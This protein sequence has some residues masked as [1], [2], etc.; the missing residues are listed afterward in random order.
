MS[1]YV[2]MPARSPSAIPSRAEAS[3]LGGSR[4]SCRAFVSRMTH[5]RNGRSSSQPAHRRELEVR[6]RVHQPRHQRA[7]A[8]ADRLARRCLTRGPDPGDAAAAP[9][10]LPRPRSK[11]ARWG[12]P[13]GRCRRSRSRTRLRGG[14]NVDCD[15]GPGP[16]GPRAPAH[17][18]RRH[19]P[20]RRCE[21]H[22]QLRL[23]ARQEVLRCSRV[24][25]HSGPTSSPVTRIN[26]A[27]R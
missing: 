5:F 21:A 22:V 9:R 12:A 26:H 1:A 13:I 27:R 3:S 6:V 16:R 23:G 15:Q 11:G 17:P 18:E 7:I 2:V 10:P 8:Q 20:G 4:T 14:P 19:C 25:A 24:P